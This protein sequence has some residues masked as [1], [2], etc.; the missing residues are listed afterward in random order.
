M[1]FWKKLLGKRAASPDAPEAGA[2]SVL[3]GGP[4]DGR[5]YVLVP[6]GKASVLLDRMAFDY[7]AGRRPGSDPRQGDL[8]GVLARMD[9]VRVL[10]G[11]LYRDTTLGAEVL[12]DSTEPEHITAFQ[13]ALRIV[14]DPGSFGHCQCLGRPTI[15][16]YCGPERLAAIA[17]H[18]GRLIRWPRWRHDA[19]LSE[20]AALESC[21]RAIG[22][23]PEQIQ[24]PGEDP[25]QFGLLSLD[26]KDRLLAR[27]QSYANRGLSAQALEEIAHVLELDPAS[28]RAHLARGYVRLEQGD[29]Q[30]VETEI[31]AALAAG[32]DGA[33]VHRVRA[34]AR[35]MVGRHE[36]AL[37][38]C[39]LAVRK[40]PNLA[41]AHH[42]RALVLCALGRLDDAVASVTESVR[43]APDR[44]ESYWLRSAIELERGR[45]REAIADLD[46]LLGQLLERGE[47]SSNPAHRRLREAVPPGQGHRVFGADRCGILITRARAFAMLGDHQ[48]ALDNLIR[49]AEADPSSIAA[50]EARA[51]FHMQ[52]DEFGPALSAHDRILALLPDSLSYLSRAQAH[53]QAGDIEAALDDS[54]VALVMAEKPEEVHGFRGELLMKAGR[55]DDARDEFDALVQLN[56]ED[57]RAYFLRAHCWNNLGVASE[58]VVDLEKAVSLDP[59]NHMALNSLAWLLATSPDDDLRDGPRALNLARQAVELTQSMDPNLLDTLAAAL[60]E[61]EQFDEAAETQRQAIALFKRL[62]FPIDLEKYRGRL[63]SY[64]IGIPTR[65]GD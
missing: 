39:D 18:H 20:P 1:N 12:F 41:A 15:E 3:V 53:F 14:E 6:Q 57:A 17:L 35:N 29:P 19:E 9:R 28:E 58:Q 56:P 11:G 22:L 65:G 5:P 44:P 64:E 54:A 50:L 40:D 36:E 23:D 25:L 7:Q 13:N 48:E 8:D 49:A 52:R 59:K 21:L 46:A 61:T 43:V 63:S 37:A 27:A 33:E 45:P 55:F 31:G 16:L 30:A 26:V 47:E 2:K 42:T 4:G 38:D 32:L 51:T 62:P 60:A 34:M 10:D 24:A